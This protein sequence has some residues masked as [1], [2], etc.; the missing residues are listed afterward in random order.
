MG[1]DMMN[2]QENGQHQ[3]KGIVLIIVL[4]VLLVML[5]AAIGLMRSVESGTAAAAN[6]SMGQS[7]Q[8][9][10]DWGVER[11]FEWLYANRANLDNDN[12]ANGYYSVRTGGG[13]VTN[14]TDWMDAANWGG[15]KTFNALTVPAPPA[16]YTVRVLVNRMCSAT[17]PINANGQSCST[18]A[19][20]TALANNTSTVKIGNVSYAI[21]ASA[22]AGGSTGGGANYNVPG[23]VYFRVT[24][25]VEGPRN[26]LS[27]IQSMLTIS[28]S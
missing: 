2:F 28:P 16:G 25:R 22:G 4:V 8:L 18:G 7:S 10:A 24:V 15:G 3:Q 19:S 9:V 12:A 23:N 21:G 14:D 20:S 1:S 6:L 27:V 26:S 5:I 17:G 11:G 13:A